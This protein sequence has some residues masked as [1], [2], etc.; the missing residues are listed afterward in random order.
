MIKSC[1]GILVYE[2]NQKIGLFFWPRIM[3][4]DFQ[5]KKLT[6][7]VVE[8]DDDDN[9]QEHIFIF[10]YVQKLL[11]GQGNNDF[12]SAACQVKKAAKICG[13]VLLSITRFFDSGPRANRR[14]SSKTSSGWAL[15]SATAGGQSSRLASPQ[16][17][18]GRSSLRESRP[19]DMLG[20]SRTP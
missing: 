2:G 15:D 4:L 5:K 18:G 7:I 17:P 6:L 20:D 11:F 12:F 9:E 3:K 16:S 8:E 19:R 1:L 13:S 14:E 10:R